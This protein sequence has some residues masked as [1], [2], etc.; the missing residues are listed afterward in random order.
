MAESLHAGWS[1]RAV[2]RA[3]GLS[4]GSV[5]NL[6]RAELGLLERGSLGAGD[7]LCVKV[8]AELGANRSTNRTS[9]D[10]RTALLLRR[11]RQAITL[12]REALAAGTLDPTVR[13]LVRDT[14]ARLVRKDLDVLATLD[15]Y[16]D[17]SM[18]LLPVGRWAAALGLGTVV[19][20]A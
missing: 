17:D 5:R 18:R 12:V 9:L 10:S 6:M 16:P 1:L 19:A 3:A 11:D 7:A 4:L 20:A 2:A 15:A 13:L 14:E 8:L